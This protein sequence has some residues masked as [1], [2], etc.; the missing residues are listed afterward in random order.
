MKQINVSLLSVAVLLLGHLSP[1]LGDTL[2][3]APIQAS[4]LPADTTGI[5]WA[6]FKFDIGA[7]TSQ[8]GGTVNEA[9]LLWPLGSVSSDGVYDFS[10]YAVKV[11]W[12]P[13]SLFSPQ[14]SV[15]MGAEVDSWLV[16]ERANEGNEGVVVR[17]GLKQIVEAWRRGDSV[18]NGIVVATR[19][20]SPEM[21]GAE[22]QAARLKV[23]CAC[24]SPDSSMADSTGS[25]NGN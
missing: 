17:L 6:A 4:V 15:S 18:N 22:L 13:E 1:V 8:Y 14:D 21:L 20:V 7:L 19:N 24:S 10:V 12:S 25:L 11:P 9:T 2:V 23:W 16:D 5:T 3:L